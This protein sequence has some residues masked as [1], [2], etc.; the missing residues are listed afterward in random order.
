M[1]PGGMAVPKRTHSS[2]LSFALGLPGA[3]EDHPW[4]EVVTKVNGKVFVF[5]GSGEGS[6]GFGMSV[7][8]DESLEQA[9]A[10]PGATPTGYGLG[11]AGWVS[12]PFGEGTPPLDVLKDWVEESYRRV[13]LKRLVKELDE[14]R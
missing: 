11:K 10:V 2:L 9:L 6:G 12:V 3:F 14:R 13:A 8:L 7:K 4:G 5:F 1:I